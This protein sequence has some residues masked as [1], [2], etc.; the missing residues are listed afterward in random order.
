MY[1]LCS[2]IPGESAPRGPALLAEIE[3]HPSAGAIFAGINRPT[4]DE[5]PSATSSATEFPAIGVA[6]RACAD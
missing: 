5:I 3:E 4:R 1:E 6:Y 2:G